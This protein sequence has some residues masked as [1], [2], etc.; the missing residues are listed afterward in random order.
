MTNSAIWWKWLDNFK[1][2]SNIWLIFWRMI[3]S[4]LPDSFTQRWIVFWKDIGY[5]LPSSRFLISRMLSH[6]DW[7]RAHTLVELGWG[8]WPM[9]RAIISKRLSWTHLTSCEIEESRYIDLRDMDT[10]DVHIMHLDA[11]RCLQAFSPE[12]VDLIVSTLPLGSMDPVHAREILAAW[13]RVLKSGG[14][15]IQYQYFAT[16]KRDI[17]LYFMIDRVDWEPLNLPPAFI[18]VCHKK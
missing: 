8:K 6:V 14:I 15:Y 12:S 3:W 10:P 2:F 1:Q 13:A 16:N 4:L 11:E 17:E 7:T 9:T 18:Y 5:G